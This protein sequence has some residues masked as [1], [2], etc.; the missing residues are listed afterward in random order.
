MEKL[1]IFTMTEYVEQQRLKNDISH[2]KTLEKLELGREVYLVW[3]HGDEEPPVEVEF[4]MMKLAKLMDRSYLYCPTRDRILKDHQ[5][6]H[7]E[8]TDYCPVCAE[9]SC[10]W[11]HKSFSALFSIEDVVGPHPE[12][13]TYRIESDRLISDAGPDVIADGG[14]EPVEGK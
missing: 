6:E 8:E 14:A 9:K 5:N 3:L 2:E 13:L 7:S 11:D 12:T 10:N 1:K 4:K